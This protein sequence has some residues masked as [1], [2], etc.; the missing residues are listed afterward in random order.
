MSYS[1]DGVEERGK[2]GKRFEVVNLTHI[3]CVIRVEIKSTRWKNKK[4]K[5]EFFFKITK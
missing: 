5:H 2:E 3:K 1:T 4:I